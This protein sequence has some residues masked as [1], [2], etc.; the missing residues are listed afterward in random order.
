MKNRNVGYVIILISLLIG[1]IIYSFN[2]ALNS[3]VNESCTHG[4]ACPMWGTINFQTNI[5][6]G[7]M[8]FV[9]L[10]GL[11]LILFGDKKKENE[12]AGT[13]SIVEKSLPNLS[14]GLG[15]DE[16]QVMDLI[17]KSDGTIFQSELVDK[18]GFGKVRITRILDKLEGKDL[19]ERRRRGMTN[20][21]LIKR[22]P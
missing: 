2:S 14:D 12:E 10:I 1:Y 21:V 5:S 16:K 7:I 13:T 4:S 17:I 15:D 22:R 9:I 6:L 11:Y 19:V 20:V 8:A 18:T 3:I